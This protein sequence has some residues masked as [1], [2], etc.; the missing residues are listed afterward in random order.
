MADQNQD[1]FS[2][3]APGQPQQQSAVPPAAPPNNWEKLKAMPS[4]IEAAPQQAQPAQ[5]DDW[6]AANAPTPAQQQAPATP[7]EQKKQGWWESTKDR[8]KHAIVDNE[9]PGFLPYDIYM[10]FH[11][12]E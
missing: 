10:H 11:P 2:Q 12:E 8:L 4:A 5:N 3:N 1:W 7:P 9:A 6:F